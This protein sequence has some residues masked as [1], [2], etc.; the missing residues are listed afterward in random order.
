MSSI[1]SGRNIVIALIIILILGVFFVV[2]MTQ[3]LGIGRGSGE[4]F[5][6]ETR[7]QR[8]F[9]PL[10]EWGLRDTSKRKVSNEDF[11]VD[12]GI[13]EIEDT[14]FFQTGNIIVEGNGKLVFKNSIVEMSPGKNPRA[15]IFVRDEAE[16]VFESST[17]KPTFHDPEN[18]Y[19]NLSGDARF[20]F[21]NSQGIHMLIAQDNS[22]IEMNNSVWAFFLPNFRGGALQVRDAALATLTNSTVG[23]IVLDLPEVARA[24]VQDFKPQKFE[25]FNLREEFG[26]QNV[27]FNIILE[28]TEVLG[29][30]YAGGSDR[31]LSIFVP[32]GI[33]S[34]KVLDSEL[35]KLVITSK[36]E[37]LAFEGLEL[38]TSNDF[39]YK[40]INFTNSRVMTQ[41]GFFIRGGVGH[42]TNSKGL[43]FF[44]Y[45]DAKLTLKN[46]EMNEFDPRNFTG[47]VD[48][49]NVIWKNAGEIIGGNNFTW[50]GSWSAQG[51][52]SVDF[53]PLAWDN[54]IVRRDFSIDVLAIDPEPAFVRAA[55]IEVFDKDNNF[56][57]ETYTNKSGRA[58]FPI[59]FDDNNFRDKFSIKVSKDGKERKHSVNFL[60]PTP[61]KLILN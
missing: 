45:D 46:S 17:L 6:K 26:L 36:D 12:S 31:G 38:D 28:N 47:S 11:V 48:F 29:D 42:F 16:L 39:F 44:L 30:Y 60:T 40:N 37:D 49:E 7:V 18:L 33:K 25:K 59:I 9:I 14:E 2:R 32:S 1:V 55:R 24:T 41:W 27:G 10:S 50:R 51:F 34:L 43:W 56:L 21:N 13:V 8:G 19:V 20:T 61:I 22:Q 15:N 54:S 3:G 52:D 4:S 35:N 57:Y 5:G 58:F 53:R 23:G